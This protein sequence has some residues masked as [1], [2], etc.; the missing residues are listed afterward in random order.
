MDWVNVFSTLIMAMGWFFIGYSLLIN[1]SFL[2][3]T[4]FAVTDF[5][6]YRRR[7][8]FAAYDES[9]GE[10]LAPRHHRADARLQRVRDD[11]RVGAGDDGHALPRLRG[12]RGRRRLQGRHRRQAGR[13]VR[14]RRGPAGR[15]P[16]GADEGRGDRDVPLPQ[17]QPQPGPRHQ[18]QRRQGRRAQR[19][20]QP[21]PQGAGLHGRRGLAARP[22]LAA[23]RVAPVRR[24]PRPGRRRRRRHPGRQRLDGHQGPRHRRT[25]AAHLAGP[26]PGRRV[27]PRVHDRPRRLVRDRGAAD[28]L[29]RLRH[30]PQGRAGRPSAG[31]PPTASARTP[32]WWSASTG[33][34]GRSGS[35]ARSS[36]SPSRSPG[37]R[38]PR[39]GPSC[40]SSG[41]A[42][43]AASPRS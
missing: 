13:R 14:P 42:G 1:T 32:S 26:G 23:A 5:I 8:E 6:G 21:G 3:L 17:G 2:L 9:F 16:P 7:I 29:R 39:T 28:H 34:S 10:P 15:R 20:H 24:P 30:L 38:R 37:P 33:G 19:G 25:H 27:P 18:V 36:S 11:H 35:T 41:A 12:H 43:T 22:R 40:A 31:W 4:V